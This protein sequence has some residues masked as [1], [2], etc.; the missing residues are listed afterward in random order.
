MKS[1]TYYVK[2][3][4]TKLTSTGLVE[5]ARNCVTMLTGNPNYPAPTTPTTAEL[6]T[7][8][9][10]LDAANQAYEFNRGKLEREARTVAFIEL[11]DLMRELGGYVQAKSEGDR[12][13]IL[14]AGLDTRSKGTPIGPLPAPGNLRA[15]VTL[16]AGRLDLRW[17]GVK[18]RSVYEVWR[19]AGDPNVAAGW[20]LI[21]LTS[22][23]R[24][25]DA[26]LVSN[27]VYHYRVV[28]QG[29]AGASPASDTAGAKAA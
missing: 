7:A 27:T 14:S 2:L 11:K 1:L 28:A 17:D 8:A 6:T 19:T 9:D 13:K 15:L 10:A 12:D 21:A 25:S 23:V 16:Y 22:K 20:S 4:F 3:G 29:P 5:K 18:G 26:G 24:Y